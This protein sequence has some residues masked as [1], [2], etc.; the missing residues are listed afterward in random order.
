MPQLLLH[1]PATV[2]TATTSYSTSDGNAI[3]P[4]TT[5]SSSS[6]KTITSTTSTTDPAQKL[7][8]SRRIV[9]M[10]HVAD[11]SRL[12]GRLPVGAACLTLRP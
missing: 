1:N 4:T 9:L 6:T 3:T 12:R 5:T 11:G 10:R 8:T 2:T 7:G